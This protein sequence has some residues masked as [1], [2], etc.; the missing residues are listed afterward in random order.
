[1][2]ALVRSATQNEIVTTFAFQLFESCE[3]TRCLN[4]VVELIDMWTREHFAYMPDGDIEVI[5]T[6]AYDI[7]LIA[8]NG[9]FDGDCD[10]VAVF[11]AALFK[12]L[13]LQTRFVA[14]KTKP[15]ENFSHV[16][17]ETLAGDEWITVDPTVPYGTIHHHYGRMIQYA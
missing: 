8:E 9:R 3:C 13:G 4:C 10:D 12:S 17:V 14:I 1:M 5:N 2:A 15:T 16:Y 11:V 6:P 7:Q